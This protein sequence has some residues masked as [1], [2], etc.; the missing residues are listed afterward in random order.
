MVEQDNKTKQG[1]ITIEYDPIQTF[2]KNSNNFF[3]KLWDNRLENTLQ[4]AINKGAD[5][6]LNEIIPYREYTES[7]IKDLNDYFTQMGTKYSDRYRKTNVPLWAW[8]NTGG[9]YNPNNN[10][11]LINPRYSKKTAEQIAVHE[12]TH[13]LQYDA[14]GLLRTNKTRTE[15]QQ[16]ALPIHT[17]NFSNSDDNQERDATIQQILFKISEKNGGVRGQNLTEVI[18]SIPTWKLNWNLLSSNG[19]GFDYWL[20]LLTDRI[21]QNDTREQQSQNLRNA[22]IY[23]KQGGKLNYLNYF[24]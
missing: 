15:L 5:F 13:R 22:L 12:G 21:K 24:N 6:V 3:H 9:L 16:K 18:K 8:F 11:I 10:R 17:W 19:Y 2:P 20:N 14:N 7:E 4:P 23:R 1:Y